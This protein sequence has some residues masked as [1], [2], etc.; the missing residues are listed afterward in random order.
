[1]K[2]FAH[3]VVPKTGLDDLILYSS[4]RKQLDAVVDL[5]KA[6]GLLYLVSGHLQWDGDYVRRKLKHLENEG[7]IRQ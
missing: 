1:M 6:R 7:L 4:L 2:S 3:R 5:E